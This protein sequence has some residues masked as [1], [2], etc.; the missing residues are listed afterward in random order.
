MG[1]QAEEKRLGQT[2]GVFERTEIIHRE[3]PPCGFSVSKRPRRVPSPGGGGRKSNR[4]SGGVYVGKTLCAERAS[5][6]PLGAEAQSAANPPLAEKASA[7]FDSLHPQGEPSLWIFF[8]LPSPGPAEGLDQGGDVPVL[9]GGVAQDHGIVRTQLPPGH[10]VLPQAPEDHPPPAG[11]RLPS[12][13]PPARPP[14]SAAGGGR[15]GGPPAGRPPGRSSPPGPGPG[16][17]S[18]SYRRCA[19]GTGAG[20]STPPPKSGGGSAAQSG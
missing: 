20:R 6:D 1:L 7:F 16:P 5:Q 12:P 14:G 15:C 18:C 10:V 11:R 2:Q 9:Q 4:F 19:S 8:V 13:S 3:S 17:P